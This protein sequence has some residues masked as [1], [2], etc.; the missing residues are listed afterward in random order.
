[1]FL[2]VWGGEGYQ[3]LGQRQIGRDRRVLKLVIFAGHPLCMTIHLSVSPKQ[4]NN[5]DNTVQ[6]N[7]KKLRLSAWH[8]QIQD[9]VTLLNPNLESIFLHHPQFFSISVSFLRILVTLVTKQ[10][11]MV[12]VGE[13]Q[14]PDLDSTGSLYLEFVYT[15][16]NIS[17]YYNFVEQCYQS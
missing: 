4:D 16:Q 10:K 5:A 6:Q 12:G 9:K 13:K 8:R 7:Q 15:M 11:L 3:N 1:M 14:M 2:D 17:N